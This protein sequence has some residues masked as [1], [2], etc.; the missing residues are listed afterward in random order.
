MGDKDQ[1]MTVFER[2]EA[3]EEERHDPNSLTQAC[4]LL[5]ES[6]GQQL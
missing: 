2:R 5:V 4:W 6:P 1:V 3:R